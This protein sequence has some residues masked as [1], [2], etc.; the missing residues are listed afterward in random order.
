MDHLPRIAVAD[1]GTNTFNLL[2]AEKRPEGGFSVLW[3]ETK[4]SRLGRN[5][6]L[7][8][9]ICD[10]AMADA[11]ALMKKYDAL[12][13]QFHSDSQIAIGTSALRQAAN[14]HFF[15]QSLE[16]QT[17]FQLSVIAGEEEA[18]LIH[19]GIL[20][21][22]CLTSKRLILDIGGGSCEFIIAE[23]GK[24][25]WKKSFEIGMVRASS[26]AL[27]DEDFQKDNT[28]LLRAYFQSAL[29]EVLSA[30]QTHQPQ[31]LVGAAGSFDTLVALDASLKQLAFNKIYPS[32]TLSPSSFEQLKN[33]IIFDS[34]EERLQYPGIIPVRAPL[35]PYAMVL[36]EETLALFPKKAQ[37][38]C[39]S[40]ALRE[41]V[42]SL[43]F[44]N[45]WRIR[46]K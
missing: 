35:L 4:E 5:G 12:A 19:E 31:D 33:K 14:S 6:G 36:I 25:F 29:S 39:T 43:V 34:Q 23:L 1:L 18:Q 16:Q 11:L 44:E 37:L 45:R 28:Q 40:Y 15:K 8:G 3:E 9:T 27:T 22:G 10:E 20:A 2:I 24:V 13:K 21:S 30:V 41:G 7:Q 38:I 42:A 17:N 46:L 32:Y 26:L